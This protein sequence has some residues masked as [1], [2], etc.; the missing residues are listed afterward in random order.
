MRAPPIRKVEVRPVRMVPA[1]QRGLT[2]RW[3][4]L[5]VGIVAE[6]EGRLVAEIDGAVEGRG[7]RR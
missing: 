3:T 5:L 7:R 6:R 2:A 1:S 4:G